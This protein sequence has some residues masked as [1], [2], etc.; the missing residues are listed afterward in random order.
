MGKAYDTINPDHPEDYCCCGCLHVKYAAIFVAIAGLLFSS[1]LIYLGLT[2]PWRFYTF[3]GVLGIIANGLIFAA[4]KNREP[5]LYLPYLALNAAFVVVQVLGLVYL[6]LIFVLLPRDTVE[7]FKSVEA[8]HP[9][10]I[11]AMAIVSYLV[12]E[13]VP[14]LFEWIVYRSHKTMKREIREGF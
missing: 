4:H 6:I 7:S 11:V 10:V 5:K 9:R 2:V 3:A 13:A 12:L 1:F 14:I 8:V